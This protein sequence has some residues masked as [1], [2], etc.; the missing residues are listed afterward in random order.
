MRLTDGPEETWMQEEDLEEVQAGLQPVATIGNRRLQGTT[1]PHV[2]KAIHQET[3]V[4]ETANGIAKE[5]EH[6]LHYPHHGQ[7]TLPLGPGHTLLA[8]SLAKKR[9]TGYQHIA[10]LLLNPTSVHLEIAIEIETVTFGTEIG[11]ETRETE[12]GK[13]AIEMKT[14]TDITVQKTW[15]A[16]SVLIETR[17]L[18][19][20]GT[21]VVAGIHTNTNMTGHTD[22]MTVSGVGVWTLI[23]LLRHLVTR[24][25]LLLCRHAHHHPNPHRHLHQ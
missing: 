5:D 25:L 19:G 6:H 7:A 11:I 21:T 4:N 12:I 23:D 1:N 9:S 13:D 16:G 17:I 18:S 24:L 14:E 22:M 8:P 15:N 3:S 2:G 10:R 20:V